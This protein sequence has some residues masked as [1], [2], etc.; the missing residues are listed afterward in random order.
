M[1]VSFR[2]TDLFA[3]IRHMGGYAAALLAVAAITATPRVSIP[4]FSPASSVR[5]SSGETIS[6]TTLGIAGSHFT[7]NGKQKF[8]LGIS[9][10]AALGAPENVVRRD[11]ADMKRHGFEWLRVWATWD[12]YDNDVSAV[13]GSGNPREPYLGKLKRLVEECDRRGLIVDVTLTRGNGAA[14]HLATLTDMSR[15]VETIVTALKPYGNWY[16]DL[17]NERNVGDKR[18]VSFDELKP[19]REAARRLDPLRLVTAS[20][21]SDIGQDELRAY[22]LTVHVDFICPHRPRVAASPGHTEA[23][24][25]EYLTWMREIGRVVPVHYQEPFRRGYSDWQP[26]AEDFA[27]DLEGARAG[28]AAGWCFHNGVNRKAED[29]RPRRSFDLRDNSLFEQL[30]EEERRF[31]A[32]SLHGQM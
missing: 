1:N 20:Q 4:R 5:I 12:A 3:R 30:D 14:P 9:Y 31:I 13:D 24:T 15:A 6:H 18:F 28:G 27:A 23:K 17:A 16:L 8:L 11:L 22:L 10:Y 32:K 7:V 25:R 29:G 2:N 19:M 21:G 26:R